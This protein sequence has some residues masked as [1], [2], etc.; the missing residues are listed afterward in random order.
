MLTKIYEKVESVYTKHILN[1]KAEYVTNLEGIRKFVKN[2]NDS[3]GLN[4]SQ[5]GRIVSLI[6]GSLGSAITDQ[7]S[8]I[9][10]GLFGS[11]TS[12]TKAQS[13]AAAL[14]EKYN[15][16]ITKSMFAESDKAGFAEYFD[17]MYDDGS[18]TSDKLRQQIENFKLTIKSVPGFLNTGAK[19]GNQ[20]A[21][22][23]ATS[24]DSKAFLKTFY[25]NTS[26]GNDDELY[27]ICKKMI[28]IYDDPKV[29]EAAFAKNTIE[30][31]DGRPT[32]KAGESVVTDTMYHVDDRGNETGILAELKDQFNAIGYS[33]MSDDEKLAALIILKK[34]CVGLFRAQMANNIKAY[35]AEKDPELV[36]TQA[37]PAADAQLKAFNEILFADVD[38]AITSLSG[39]SVSTIDSEL[40]SNMTNATKYSSYLASS[41]AME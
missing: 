28:A 35:S 31:V 3:P 26:R 19:V 15:K 12:L 14:S 25:E 21:Y 38:E 11:D 5:K 2:V 39:S 4:D 17:G 1:N 34:K 37:I 27:G 22:F 41:R 18:G 7:M 8:T 23:D 32:V 29:S 30:V 36:R 20:E 6:G 9:Y 10:E 33:S 24:A 13:T 16:M 40:R